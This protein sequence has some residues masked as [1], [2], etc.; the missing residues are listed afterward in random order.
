MSDNKVLA[1]G[2]PV[3]VVVG[4]LMGGIACGLVNSSAGTMSMDTAAKLLHCQE[5]G[6]AA[7]DDAGDAMAGWQAY[8][9]CKTAEGL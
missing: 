4:I 5:E 1:I 7:K 3:V 6:I 2:V 8:V 9:D